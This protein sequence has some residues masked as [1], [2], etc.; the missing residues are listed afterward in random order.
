MSTFWEFAFAI[1]IPLVVILL[2]IFWPERISRNE[3]RNSVRAI[4]DR[5]SLEDRARRV[6]YRD[7]HRE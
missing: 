1:G 4:L 6:K 2:A 7:R 5:I 3:S